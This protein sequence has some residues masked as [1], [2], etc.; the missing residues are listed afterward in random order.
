MWI[1]RSDQETCPIQVAHESSEHLFVLSSTT[2]NER[3]LENVQ[4][5]DDLDTLSVF[6]PH[7]ANTLVNVGSWFS[8]LKPGALSTALMWL[9]LLLT[10]SSS[11]SGSKPLQF[12]TA[13]S[14]TEP[15]QAIFHLCQTSVPQPP[16]PFA[17]LCET[18]RALTNLHHH[19]TKAKPSLLPDRLG[20]DGKWQTKILGLLL[21]HLCYHISLWG[22]WKWIKRSW[23]VTVFLCQ[24]IIHC[25][26]SSLARLRRRELGLEAQEI[27]QRRQVGLSLPEMN[28]M[29]RNK[30]EGSDLKAN[31]H[32]SSRHGAQ[33]QS[34]NKYKVLFSEIHASKA[35]KVSLPELSVLLVQDGIR[36][37]RTQMSYL[38]VHSCHPQTDSPNTRIQNPFR[39]LK[40][41]PTHRTFSK[42]S[43]ESSFRLPGF[44]LQLSAALFPLT[45]EGLR[46]LPSPA[47][48]MFVGKHRTSDVGKGTKT[49][50]FHF[51]V[52]HGTVKFSA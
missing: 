47:L 1:R 42:T 20:L 50:T 37:F 48:E 51:P 10:A 18:W 44:S 39:R 23:S 3:T 6:F 28:G 49:T 14:T 52:A 13:V 22:L 31:S 12:K 8:S 17:V 4:G 27:L 45:S 46:P 7:Y 43:W 15:K 2:L 41:K 38:W 11:P 30:R 25:L 29:N 21:I 36:K 9:A 19:E 16:G 26:A 35:T 40:P 33:L 32:Q 34:Q 24:S 5:W